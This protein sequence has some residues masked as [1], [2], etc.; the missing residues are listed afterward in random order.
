M[1]D[2]YWDATA[3]AVK[4][5]DLVAAG[6]FKIDHDAR[7]AALPQKPEDYK[8][9][10]KAP[11]GFK[12]PE[13]MKAEDI[14]ID[15]KDARIPALRA[16]AHEHKLSQDQVNG[17]VALHIQAQMAEYAAADAELQAEMKKLGENGKTR[18]EAANAFLKQHLTAEEHAAVRLFIGNSTAFTGLEKII[19]KA[20][21]QSVPPNAG[22]NPNPPPKPVVRLADRLYGQKAS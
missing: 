14:K 1:A 21:T 17:L 9:E 3:N 13:G 6:Q 8:V 4:M 10:W 12:A 20:L 2:H 16:F 11:E 19:A 22:G 15:E 18:V 5:P 7:I